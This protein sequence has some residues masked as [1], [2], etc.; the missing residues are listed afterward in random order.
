[1]KVKSIIIFLFLG[2]IHIAASAQVKIKITDLKDD[3]VLL[4]EFEQGV[5]YILDTI[6]VKKGKLVVPKQLLRDNIIYGVTIPSLEYERL[7]FIYEGNDFAITTTSGNLLGDVIVTGNKNTAVL[8]QDLKLN[9]PLLNQLI[10]IQ[11]KADKQR[12]D[13]LLNLIRYNRDQ[14]LNQNPDL[15]WTQVN[16]VD[17]GAKLPFFGNEAFKELMTQYAAFSNGKADFIDQIVVENDM[18]SSSKMLER[19]VNNLINH[20]D[21]YHSDSMIVYMDSLFSK[22]AVNK[23]LYHY[24]LKLYYHRFNTFSDHELE[25]AMMHYWNNYLKDADTE[26]IGVLEHWEFGKLMKMRAYTLIGEKAGHFSVRD[27]DF[28]KGGIVRNGRG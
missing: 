1:M 23:V 11:N 2:F 7:E 4:S 16:K 6:K 12:E 21:N 9:L 20:P 13:S 19:R 28:N 25:K 15:V 14:I 18:L 8:Y 3:F 17:E 10:E 26:S 22:V 24:I 5:N 27:K